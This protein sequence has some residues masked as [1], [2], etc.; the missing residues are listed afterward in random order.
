MSVIEPFPTTRVG[1]IPPRDPTCRWLLEQLWGHRAVGIIGGAPKASKSWLAL[2]MAVSVASGT[3]CLGRFEVA[4]AGPALI[5]LAEDDA[6]DVRERV[7]QLC[8]HRRL[9]LDALDVELL[10]TPC[11]RLDY[12][13]DRLRLDA[14]LAALRPR[15]LVLDPLVRLHQSLDENSSADIARLLGYLRELNRRHD[16]A[17]VLVHHMSKKPRKNL[18][19]ALRGSSDLHAWVDSACYLV[20]NHQDQIQLTVEHRAAPAPKPLLLRLADDRPVRLDV[21]D[22]LNTPPPIAEVVRQV[23]LDAAAPLTR[24]ALRKQLRINNARLGEALSFLEARRLACR[25]PTGW[26]ITNGADPRQ[27]SLTG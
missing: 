1:A 20:R 10:T 3:P 26:T 12:E 22:T 11:L 15:L 4:S 7:E 5:Y 8:E 16:L 27:L 24:A 14:T 17:V 23:L 9:S 18:G 19:Q 6:P 25:T 2:D 13:E 21:V